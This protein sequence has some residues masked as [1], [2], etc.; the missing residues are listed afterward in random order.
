M[1]FS[2]RNHIIINCFYI[3]L[4]I[5]RLPEEPKAQKSPEYITLRENF[6]VFTD[7]IKYDN[8]VILQLANHLFAGGVI[9]EATIINIMSHGIFLPE[10]AEILTLAVLAK[11]NGPSPNTAFCSL[12]NALEKIRLTDFATELKD[13][14]SKNA[15]CSMQVYIELLLLNTPLNF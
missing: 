2:F 15:V 12:I 3:G 9:L 13:Y 8:A 14:L 5:Q 4:T 7:Q 11:L 6:G 10:K 1:H